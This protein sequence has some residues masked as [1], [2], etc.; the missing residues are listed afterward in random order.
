MPSGIADYSEEL[1]PY[2]GQYFDLTVYVEDGLQPT[3]R[4]LLRSFAVRPLSRL[5]RDQRQQPFDALLY[6]IG[7]SPAHAQ[8]WTAMKQV[9]GVVVLHEFVLNHFMLNYAAVVQRNVAAY[10]AEAARRYGA[11]GQRVAQLMLRGRLSEAAFQY[12][13]SETLIEAAEGLIAHSQYVLDLVTT[14]RPS[15]PMA[16]VP[17]GVPP[18]PLIERDTARARQGLPVAA[19]ILASFGH[20]NPYKR[21]E[22]VLRALRVLRERHHGLRYILVGSVSPNFDPEGT[23]SAPRPGRSGHDYGLC[24]AKRVRGLCGR[25]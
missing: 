24:R 20:I 10:E 13:F 9:P 22:P 23:D 8:I 6:H 12:P 15:L 16:L 3:N 2:L 5:A 25:R 7:N 11:E 18:P 21:I 19:P 14:V 17:M 4:D 1:L